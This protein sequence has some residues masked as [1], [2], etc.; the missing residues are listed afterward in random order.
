[1]YRTY[2]HEVKLDCNLSE[3]TEGDLYAVLIWC[4]IAHRGLERVH[5][6]F[7]ELCKLRR[8][9]CYECDS[10]IELLLQ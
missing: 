7:F 8:K 5:Y 3:K 6:L 2:I 9:L 4:V 1:M 10:R